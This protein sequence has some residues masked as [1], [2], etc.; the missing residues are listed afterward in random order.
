MSS[1]RISKR[2]RWCFIALYPLYLLGLVWL[3]VQFFWLLQEQKTGKSKTDVWG[4]YYS[5]LS[6]VQ[7][8]DIREN[9]KTFDVLLLGASV[10]EQVAP[11]LEKTMAS[12][13]KCPV[14]VFS[15]CTSAHTSR[16]SFLKYSQLRD[17]PFDLVMIYHGIND[18]RMNCIP[19]NL[20]QQDYTHCAHY[21]SFQRALEAGSLSV[22]GVVGD[23]V[24]QLISLGEPDPEV[25]E[26]GKSIKTPQAFR[27]NL[28]AI[29][30]GVKSQS[31]QV[32]LMT[33]AT[34][35]PPNYSK[36]KFIEKQLGYGSGQYELPIEVWGQ[37]DNVVAAIKA[38]NREL[39]ELAEKSEVI[40]IDQAR[41]I[42]QNGEQ[43]SDICHLTK[44]GCQTFVN[45][46][47]PDLRKLCS[48][49]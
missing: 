5:K 45:N 44:T 16:D 46:V 37:P 32:M 12:E 38:H 27:T 28:E 2:R 49:R 21:R 13:L 20:Y 17:K 41:L 43:F 26:F 48:K 39:Q 6:P 34:W 18:A 30:R 40:F 4:Y 47:M 25:V 11:V 3:G 10:L 19:D 14:R 9:D 42:P 35:V 31:G 24:D 22:R 36:T 1:S 33:F 29:V 8:A 23:Q 7:K 15:V